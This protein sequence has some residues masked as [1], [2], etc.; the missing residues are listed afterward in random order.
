MN[1]QLL[2][3]LV[4]A[5]ALA[6]AA[7]PARAD[8]DLCKDVVFQFTNSHASQKAIRVTKVS[9]FNVV[10]GTYPTVNVVNKECTYGATCRLDAVDLRDAEGT[11]IKD[12]TFTYQEK[13]R[14]NNW[15]EPW[16]RGAG[17]FDPK[18]KT[19]RAGKVYE[20][21]AITGTLTPT[22]GGTLKPAGSAAQPR[23]SAVGTATLP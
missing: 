22:Q 19:C 16:S 12:I 17:P 20:A 9:Y 4:A 10:N 8:D 21:F 2:C 14:Q 23:S 11:N 13:D 3:T 5:T 15:M 1:K 7:Q 18:A 6:S